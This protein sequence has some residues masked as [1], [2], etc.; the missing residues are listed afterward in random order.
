M[1]VGYIVWNTTKWEKYTNS[2]F[3]SKCIT[4]KLHTRWVVLDVLRV[5][6]CQTH[7]LDVLSKITFFRPATAL[8][9]FRL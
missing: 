1:P 2:I 7:V 9:R 4:R 8:T 6:W 5:P 3:S